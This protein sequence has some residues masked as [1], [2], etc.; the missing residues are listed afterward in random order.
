MI[1]IW[2]KSTPWSYFS[3]QALTGSLTLACLTSWLT[4][5]VFLMASLCGVLHKILGL[6]SGFPSSV[7]SV[8]SLSDLFPF[9]SKLVAFSKQKLTFFLNLYFITRKDRINLVFSG[10]GKKKLLMIKLFPKI[11]SWVSTVHEQTCD[12]CMHMW[13]I[14]RLESNLTA[15]RAIPSLYDIRVL[16]ANYL[17]FDLEIKLKNESNINS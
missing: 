16:T 7:W 1:P 12:E 10:G 9:F 6:W 5:F 2:W 3:S 4:L 14:I 13:W 11:F 17:S 8:L 15:W